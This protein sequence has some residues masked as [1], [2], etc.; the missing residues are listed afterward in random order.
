MLLDGLWNEAPRLEPYGLVG[1]T[2]TW[3]A[4]AWPSQPA[5]SQALAVVGG[6]IGAALVDGGVQPSGQEGEP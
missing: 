3:S 5:P 6:T 4:T 1:G 2:T